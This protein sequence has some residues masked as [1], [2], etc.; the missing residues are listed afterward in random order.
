MV[1][2]NKCCGGGG[3][4]LPTF[5][6]V[7]HAL[8]ICSKREAG[9]NVP[10]LTRNLQKFRCRHGSPMK[11]WALEP[12]SSP[13]ST[14][15]MGD[16]RKSVFPRSEVVVSGVH[17]CAYNQAFSFWRAIALTCANGLANLLHGG[18]GRTAFLSSREGPFTILSF[19]FM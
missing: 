12:P 16:S 2:R 19:L 1:P 5:Q 3:Q 8:Q 7:D 17:G 14:I 9:R 4:T 13:S 6:Q 15:L 10:K 18:L 11:F